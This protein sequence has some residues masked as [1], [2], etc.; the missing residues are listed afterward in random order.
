MGRQENNILIL[1]SSILAGFYQNDFL[2]MFA[3]R[4]IQG[5]GKDDTGETRLADEDNTDVLV[6]FSPGQGRQIDS[7]IADAIRSAKKRVRIASMVISSGT[8]LGAILDA[9]EAGVDVQG[10]YD[11]TQMESALKSIERAG[12]REGK[13]AL[14]E[15]ATRGFAQKRSTPYSA[16][17]AHDFMHDK[18][19]VVDNS[20]FTGSFNFSTNA[21]RN[22]ENCVRVNSKS[23][24]DAYCAHIDKVIER[25]S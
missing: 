6:Q 22:A 10:V 5:T 25:Y 17:S 16:E 14:F 4:S 11:G 23:L 12:D 24:A 7:S 20:V 13:K 21:T 2:E 19:A 18:I 1:E 8:I 3:Q 9:R 15:Q